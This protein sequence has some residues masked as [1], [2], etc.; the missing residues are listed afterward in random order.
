MISILIVLKADVDGTLRHHVTQLSICIAYMIYY[1]AKDRSDSSRCNLTDLLD[2]EDF[3]GEKEFV[4][5]NERRIVL[6][7]YR[8]D[9][10]G[11][12]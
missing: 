7:V 8:S 11:G 12:I 9:G 6:I 2:M 5:K 3:P 10:K 4:K 1:F